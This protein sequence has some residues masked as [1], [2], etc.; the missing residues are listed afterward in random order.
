MKRA[1]LITLMIVLAF[2]SLAIF[3]AVLNRQIPGSQEEQIYQTLTP[4]K[5]ALA[6]VTAPIPTATQQQTGK[7]TFVYKYTSVIP[8]EWFNGTD[9]DRETITFSRNEGG[10]SKEKAKPEFLNLGPLFPEFIYDSL[11][12]SNGVCGINTYLS[13]GNPLKI[14]FQ[15]VIEVCNSISSEE[16]ATITFGLENCDRDIYQNLVC[17][18]STDNGI[19]NYSLNPTFD[20][21]QFNYVNTWDYQYPYWINQAT[22]AL[23]FPPV[24]DN[25][26]DNV[27]P[28]ANYTIYKTSP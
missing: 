3:G 12:N 5:E 13:D 27:F 17:W 26:Y 2:F 28:G 15:P 24:A 16:I 23:D 6:T 18:V 21:F 4:A 10:W 19:L 1:H 11:S 8:R 20:K 14:N 9:L 22:Q 7:I 25:F